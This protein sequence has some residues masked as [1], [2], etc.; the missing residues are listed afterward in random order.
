MIDPAE[1]HVQVF[2]EQRT[3]M[4]VGMPEVVIKVTHLPTG[5]VAY[6]CGERSQHANRQKAVAELEAPAAEPADAGLDAVAEVG[7]YDTVMWLTTTP[8][9]GTKLYT[10]P[11]SEAAADAARFDAIASQRIGLTPEFE[12]P[13]Y[14]EVYGEEGHVVAAYAGITPR[15]AIDAALASP[16]AVKP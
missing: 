9:A 5:R 11:P 7:N 6:G 8:E 4:K 14:A 12:G 1:L 3:G 16:Q 2:A 13:W 15:E 10:R